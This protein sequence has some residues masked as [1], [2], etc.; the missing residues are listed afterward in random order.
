MFLAVVVKVYINQMKKRKIRL[1]AARR[2]Y[3][4]TLSTALT[5]R[6]VSTKANAISLILRSLTRLKI[7]NITDLEESYKGASP[8]C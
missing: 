1:E 6:R 5:P 2:I 4:R 3:L 7:L 8:Q